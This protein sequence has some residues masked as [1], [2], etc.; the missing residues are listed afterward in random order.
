MIYLF[1]GAYLT[2]FLIQNDLKYYYPVNIKESWVGKLRNYFGE[3]NYRLL[4][5]EIIDSRSN[6]C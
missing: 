2:I 4:S 3:S 1:D 6:F 5:L